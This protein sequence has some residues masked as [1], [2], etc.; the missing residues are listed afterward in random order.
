VT[1]KLQHTGIFLSWCE[2]SEF[3]QP[4]LDSKI[5]TAKFVTFIAVCISVKSQAVLE[6]N[7]DYSGVHTEQAL[8]LNFRCT[9][10]VMQ[11]LYHV[12]CDL[13]EL[14]GAAA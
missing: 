8:N 4:K 7:H 3:R 9:P 2:G 12:V 10:H 1:F 11:W 6:S 13:V 5:W 14:F